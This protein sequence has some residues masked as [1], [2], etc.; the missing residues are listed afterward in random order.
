MGTRAT[1]AHVAASTLSSSRLEV[2]PTR[3][4][5]AS[6]STAWAISCRTTEFQDRKKPAAE[7]M[8]RWATQWA[9]GIQQTAESDEGQQRQGQQQ[10]DPARRQIPG[11][12]KVSKY[13]GKP[14]SWPASWLASWEGMLIGYRR[15][16][17][18]VMTSSWVEGNGTRGKRSFPARFGTKMSDFRLNRPPRWADPASEP[19]SRYPR[20]QPA[21]RGRHPRRDTFLYILSA[22]VP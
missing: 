11:R 22:L 8:R 19:R 4:T 12:R 15:S 18:K 10:P 21:R 9:L 2:R 1:S 3:V 5:R 13:R 14:A 17:L 16:G 20:G 6:P 7:A